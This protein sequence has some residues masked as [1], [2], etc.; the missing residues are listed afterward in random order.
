MVAPAAPSSNC[1]SASGR[2]RST[3]TTSRWVNG[4]PSAC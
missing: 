2:P 1:S 4:H 3:R